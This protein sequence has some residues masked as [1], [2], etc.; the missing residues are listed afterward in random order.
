[1]SLLFLGAVVVLWFGIPIAR[2]LRCAANLG[3][4]IDEA[5][6]MSHYFR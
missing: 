6:S 5:R 2:S 4:M 1:M 3:P